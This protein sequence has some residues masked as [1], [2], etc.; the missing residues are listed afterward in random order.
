LVDY[1]LLR[2]QGYI[3]LGGISYLE[4]LLRSLRQG[5]V[6]VANL[7]GAAP[8]ILPPVVL[9]GLALAFLRLRDRE[10]AL[11]WVVLVFSAAS[12]LTLFPRADRVHLYFA[13]PAILVGAVYL[14]NR[15]RANL[16]PAGVLGLRVGALAW[17]TTGLVVLLLLPIVQV[18]SG[19][20]QVSTIPR[21]R[22][23]LVRPAVEASALRT[24]R[25]FA[26]RQ[27]GPTLLLSPRAGFFYLVTGVQNPTPYDVPL[28]S[29]LGRRGEEEVIAAIERGEVAYVCADWR[30]LTGH[31]P[32]RPWRL[33]SFVRRELRKEVNLGF[34][35][36]Y[37]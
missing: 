5:P 25:A 30:G 23:A 20:W 35:T 2:K 11:A 3:E 19:E 27:P 31:G 15:F 9:V 24:S 4:G 36:L 7:Y 10:R 34:C 12:A 14:W 8:F 22:F 33:E 17:T 37:R 32:Q 21:F 1:G 29:A 28:M 6:G 16:R 18:G 13:L 26:A